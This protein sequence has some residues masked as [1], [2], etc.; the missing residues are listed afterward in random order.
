MIHQLANIGPAYID[1]GTGSFIIQA[2]IAGV[3][4]AAFVIKQ[5]WAMLRS[6]ISQRRQTGRHGN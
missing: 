6:F 2:T 3:L 1:G 4:S 5:R